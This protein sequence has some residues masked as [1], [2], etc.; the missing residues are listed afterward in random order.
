MAHRQKR[1]AERRRDGYKLFVAAFGAGT[2]AAREARLRRAVDVGVDKADTHA[3]A[4]KRSGKIGRDGR[5]ADP[6]LPACHGDEAARGLVGRERD[7]DFLDARDGA[8]DAA[9]IGFDCR[10]PALIETRNIEDEADAAA[11]NSRRAD[12]AR[13]GGKRHESGGNGRRIDHRAAI[14]VQIAT[15]PL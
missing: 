9:D 13:A 8:E 7:A 4:V 3:R 6:A 10:T 2:F 12:A 14:A 1:N 15:R 5:F 11:L